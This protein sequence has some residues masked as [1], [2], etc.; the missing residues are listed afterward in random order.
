MKI[1][2]K[3]KCIF[4]LIDILFVWEKKKKKIL[5][6]FEGFYLFFFGLIYIYYN[7]SFI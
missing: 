2:N 3:L 4:K 5:F 1:W 7:E 6:K